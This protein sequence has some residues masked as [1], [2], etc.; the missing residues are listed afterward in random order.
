ER[1][2]VVERDAQEAERKSVAGRLRLRRV[3]LDDLLAALED[4]ADAVLL[5]RRRDVRRREVGV[6]AAHQEVAA[7]A[8]FAELADFAA[9]R[10]FCASSSTAFHSA[11]VTGWTESRPFFTSAIDASRRSPFTSSSVTGRASF[12]T[13]FS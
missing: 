11:A 5:L 2:V 7:F 3:D 10:V 8:A 9:A 13:N 6:D 1:H 12:S 4:E